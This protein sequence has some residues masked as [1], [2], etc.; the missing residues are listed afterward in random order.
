LAL[1]LYTNNSDDVHLE[2]MYSVRYSS[3]DYLPFARELIKNHYDNKQLSKSESDSTKV[4]I[5][6]S[7][8]WILKSL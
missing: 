2:R 7:S 3:K 8:Y 5:T 4:T 1:S 6:Y